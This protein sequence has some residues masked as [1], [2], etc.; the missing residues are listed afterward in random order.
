MGFQVATA[1]S[2]VTRITAAWLNSFIRDPLMDL[3]ERC[4]SILRRISAYDFRFHPPLFTTTARD[5]LTNNEN[6]DVIGNTTTGKLNVYTASGWVEVA[7]SGLSDWSSLTT[8][9]SV[10][11]GMFLKSDGLE[12]FSLTT[13]NNELMGAYPNAEVDDTKTLHPDGHSGFEWRVPVHANVKTFDVAG[14]FDWDVPNDAHMLVL[15][16]LGGGG[17]GGG[18]RASATANNG[19]SVGSGGGG[20][21]RGQFKYKIEPAY[22]SKRHFRV[23]IGAGGVGG[24]AESNGSAGHSS[25]IRVRNPATG[26]LND[27]ILSCVGGDYGRGA[28]SGSGGQG[29]STYDSQGGWGAGTQGDTLGIADDAGGGP[30]GGFYWYDPPGGLDSD[31]FLKRARDGGP[32]GGAY[33]FL[34][35]ISASTGAVGGA[36][37][38]GTNNGSDGADAT[39]DGNYFGK[40]AG[41]G[42]GAV[43]GDGGDG[44]DGWHGSGGGG[45][46][47]C[48][49]GHTPGT[50]GRGADAVIRFIY[51]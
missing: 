35:G 45:G 23:H 47:G 38:T 19:A 7:G 33:T 2:G 32:G 11:V 40:G 30:G 12:S 51:W 44:G 4:R 36:Q 28:R 13:V 5:A 15:M 39:S 8:S 1:K 48:P 26:G 43:D 49:F 9:D 17:G 10:P 27:T 18:G 3:D 20:G 16:G 22:L 34:S 14:D 21:A 46:A 37:G 25:W 29:G 6:L 41:G 50:G 42:G 24:S 31:P